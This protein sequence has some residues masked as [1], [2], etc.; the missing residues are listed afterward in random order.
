MTRRLKEPL[1]PA[2]SRLKA[3]ARLRQQMLDL[4]WLLAKSG[5]NEH[6]WK[7]SLRMSEEG[8]L[9]VIE[10]VL[11]HRELGKV[12]VSSVPDPA[13]SASHGIG[14]RHYW[15]DGNHWYD[16]HAVGVLSDQLGAASAVEELCA[17]AVDAMARVETGDVKRL[18][19][20][21]EKVRRK[22]GIVDERAEE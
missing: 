11:K 8:T 2:L 12:S 4:E 15:I 14:Q 21:I 13:E 18:G 9:P 22:F 16:E 17:A 10:L 3:F 20:A 5:W 6:R 1:A 7:L 19:K